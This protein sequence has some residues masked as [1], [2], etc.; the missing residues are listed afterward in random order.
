MK[1]WH[2]DLTVNINFAIGYVPGFLFYS[3]EICSF[4]AGLQNSKLF[5]ITKALVKKRIYFRNKTTSF[6]CTFSATCF[7]LLVI[8]SSW[9]RAHT[10]CW[11]PHRVVTG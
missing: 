1:K 4:F 2:K 5:N 7:F 8:N 11:L 6:F 10:L 3:S 9:A